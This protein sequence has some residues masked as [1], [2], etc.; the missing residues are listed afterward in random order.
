[1]TRI[2]KVEA[3]THN[4]HHIFLL[5]GDEEHPGCKLSIA[6][7]KWYII[8]G[9]PP[10]IRPHK[11]KVYPKWNADTVARMGR[12]WYW[13]ITE[14]EYGVSQCDNHVCFRYGIQTND[15]STEK[16]WGFFL[17]WN[18]WRMVRHSLYDLSGEHVWSQ[19]HSRGMDDFNE[20]MKARERVPKATFNFKDFDGEEIQAVTHI[21]EREWL[22]GVKWFKW[23]SWFWKPKVR[24]DLDIEFSKETGPRKGSWKGGTI[25]HGIEMLA[26]EDTHKSAFQRY[27]NEHRMTLTEA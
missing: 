2:L 8:I 10:I 9:L 15:S 19:Y 3:N 25:G 20:L 22:R 26:A 13:R 12:D 23:L 24:R 6:A 5:S 14:R 1:M 4:L 18:E 21:E 16:S 11:V 17:P 27:C 7:W